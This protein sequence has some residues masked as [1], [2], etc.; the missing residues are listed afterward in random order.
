MGKCEFCGVFGNMNACGDGVTGYTIDL[1]NECT[2]A[3]C[4]HTL[5]HGPH[6]RLGTWQRRV[7]QDVL[8]K[9]KAI[10][11]GSGTATEAEVNAAWA[12]RWLGEVLDADERTV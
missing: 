10:E 5:P 8:Q 12:R 6:I 3:R 4:D 9:I 7:L 11:D 2:L 1:C